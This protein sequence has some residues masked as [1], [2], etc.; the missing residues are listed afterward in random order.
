[1]GKLFEQAKEYFDRIPD[2]HRN[3]IQRPWNR[4]V[5]RSLRKMIERANNNGDCIINVGNGIYRPIPGDPVDEK[6]LNE[7]LGKELHRAR[8]IQI[9]R[10]SMKQTFEGTF[11]GWRNSAAYA[12]HFRQARQSE[13]LHNSLQNESI[14][15]GASESKERAKS[16]G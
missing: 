15:R 8:A 2:G 11:E 13:R 4:V 3:A 14:Q 1:M 7:Y 10:L 12:N 5:D 16:T 6:E 9:K